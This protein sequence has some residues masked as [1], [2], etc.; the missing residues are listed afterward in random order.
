VG[1]AE[2][3]PQPRRRHPGDHPDPGTG[4]HAQ[5][6]RLQAPPKILEKQCFGS[7]GCNITFRVQVDYVGPAALDS[8]TRYEVT[9]EVRGVED[10]PQVNTLTIQDDQASVDSKEFASVPSSATKLKVVAT[11]VSEA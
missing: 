4:L 1:A 5:A 2:R 6:R 9:Y 3:P 10:G 7:A 8:G 11:D